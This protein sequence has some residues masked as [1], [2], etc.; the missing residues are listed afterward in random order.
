MISKG[1][2]PLQFYCLFYQGG[3]TEEIEG[4]G[5]SWGKWG[6]T[7]TECEAGSAI[8]GMATEYKVPLI[9]DNTGATNFRFYCC[10][11]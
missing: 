7:S 1:L 3:S 5:E 4:D 8:C 2:R 10:T 6:D 11:Q 9:G